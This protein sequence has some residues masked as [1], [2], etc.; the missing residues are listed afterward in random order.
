MSLA[1]C[2]GCAQASTDLQTGSMDNVE[3]FKLG[4]RDLGD[5]NVHGKE[6][7]NRKAL[8]AVGGGE[9]LCRLLNTDPVRGITGAAGQ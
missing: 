3:P 1:D 6:E 8:H 4:V 5:L 7:E 2:C 9:G